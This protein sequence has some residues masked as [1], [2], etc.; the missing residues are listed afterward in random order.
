MKE[1]GLIAGF[2]L[3]AGTASASIGPC[4]QFNIRRKPFLL[5]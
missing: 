1:P 3:P 4:Y 5:G 2:F